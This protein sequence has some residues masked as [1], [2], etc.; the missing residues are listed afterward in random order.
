M[1]APNDTR[2]DQKQIVA[3]LAAQCHVPVCDMELLY[4]HE[5]VALALGAR[6]TKFLHI[7][8]IRNVLE[9][10]RKRDMDKPSLRMA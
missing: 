5:R 6:N 3:S 4:E 10:F 1:S 7:F 8:A 2:P 9:A